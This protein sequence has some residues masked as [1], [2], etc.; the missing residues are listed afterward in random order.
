M[1]IPLWVYNQGLWE[2]GGCLELVRYNIKYLGC[3]RCIKRTSQQRS[4]SLFLQFSLF[5]L[6][7]TFFLAFPKVSKCTRL[8]AFK[9]NTILLTIE[10]CH[11]MITAVDSTN[12]GRNLLRT[13]LEHVSFSLGSKLA[14]R[15]ESED[16]GSNPGAASHRDL[17]FT[18]T[19]DFSLL[20]RQILLQVEEKCTVNSHGTK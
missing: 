1:C 16:V 3:W 9:T 15:C 19:L 12:T 18:H 2:L 6:R 20:V 17:Q 7:E 13:D 10:I 14:A 4:N 11:V 5:F 8:S